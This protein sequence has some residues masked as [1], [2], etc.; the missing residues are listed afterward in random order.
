[1]LKITRKQVDDFFMQIA[2]L[3]IAVVGDVMIDVYYWGQTRRISPEAPV[4]VVEINKEEI[5]PGGAAN[6]ALNI[7]TLEA[8]AKMFGLIG[9]DDAGKKLINSFK[10]DGIS[11]EYLTIDPER[12]TTVKTR[13][14]AAN[15]HVVRF[16]KEITSD[17]SAETEN[18]ILDKLERHIHELDA[19]ILEDYNKGMLTERVIKGIIKI[20]NQHKKIVTVDPKLRN[21]MAYKHATLF[22]PNLK[23]AEQILNRTIH[24]D[25]EIEKAGFDLLKLLECK[26]VV[27]TLSERGVALFTKDQAMRI[28]PARSTKIAN[29]SGA[30]DT[31]IATLTAALAAGADFAISAA[32]ANYAASVVV[33]D[34]SIVPIYRKDLISRLIE[35][36]IVSE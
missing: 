6:V 27:I 1:M 10:A 36:G 23:E 12:P 5:K 7:H 21:F 17:I 25:E 19:I 14:M 2:K 29:V 3:N 24:T 11:P 34:V 18:D 9:N 13:V 30:G 26:Y 20:A 4:P 16:D 28:I 35:S 22:K 32:L 8:K 33:E 15:Q 31:V